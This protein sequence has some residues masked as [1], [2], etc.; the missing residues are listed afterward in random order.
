MDN[1]VDWGICCGILF[2]NYFLIRGYSCCVSYWMKIFGV[3]W[4]RWCLVGMCISRV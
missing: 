1:L 2:S 3:L 4:G